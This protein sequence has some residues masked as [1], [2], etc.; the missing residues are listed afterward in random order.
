MKMKL[1]IKRHVCGDMVLTYL[2][3]AK[4]KRVGFLMVPLKKE[5]QVKSWRET[6]DGV[7]TRALPKQ[8]LDM[9]RVR[10]VES[11]VQVH[12]RGDDMAGSHAQGRTMRNGASTLGLKWAG[13]KV[14]KTKEKT[15]ILTALKSKHGYVCQH[16]VTWNCGDEGIR[17][18][19]E[20]INNKDKPIQVDYLASFSLGPLTPFH[21]ADAPKRMILHRFRSAWSA[22]GRLE[23][24]PLEELH[25]ERSWVGHPPMLERFGQAGSLPVR[26]YFPWIG[27][28]DRE[29]KVI[30]GAQLAWAGSWQMQ[31]SRSDDGLHLSGGLNDWEQGHWSK[32][33]A[34][35]EA[36]TTPSAY[37]TTCV[38]GIEECCYRLTQ[39]QKYALEQVPTVEKDL[40]IICNEFCHTWGKPSEDA[41]LQLADRLQDTPVKYLVMDAGWHISGKDNVTDSMGDWIPDKKLFPDGLKATAQRIREKGL[42]PGIWFEMENCG[43]DALAFNEKE[44]FLKRDG[45]PIY[46][47]NRRFWDFRDPWVI[48]YLSERVIGLLRDCGFGYLKVDYNETIGYGC[49]GAES[50]GEGLRQHLEGVQAFFRKIRVELPDLVI[51]NCAS[52]G[53]RLEPSMMVLCSMGSSTD[54]HETVEGPIIAANMQRLILPSQSQIWSVLRPKDS[55]IRLVYSLATSFLGRMCLSGD[56]AELKPTQ[57]KLAQQAMNLYRKVWP[58]IKEGKSFRLGTATELGSYRH[59]EGWQAVVRIEKDQKRI[60]VVVHSFAKPGVKEVKI[61]LEEITGKRGWKMEET[62]V[63][64][65]HQQPSLRTKTYLTVPISSLTASVC[66]LRR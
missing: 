26:G 39:M 47:S 24:R 12:V 63:A 27:V 30:W 55:D 19:V 9:L 46:A 8:V 38:G 11:M 32:I 50:P 18:E 49:D 40:P 54:A 5:K 57:W 58:I 6:L 10:D 56:L 2:I 15:H 33:L 7:E 3:D 61:N 48:D 4:T 16:R 29:A 34:K 28:E 14:K 20:L 44:H 23:S 43:P 25:L 64:S 35:G 65:L 1:M 42:I 13:Q 45:I 51:E 22:E 62:F 59:P 53:T 17:V 66:V 37:L 36:F 31:A 52:G 60:L 21:E 41:M